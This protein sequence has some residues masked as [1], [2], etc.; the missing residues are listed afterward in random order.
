MPYVAKQTILE[1]AGLLQVVR[2]EGLAGT[3]NGT[4]KV[5]TTDYKPI[6]DADYDDSVDSSDVAVYVGGVKVVVVGVVAETG[7]ITLRD[8]PS[9]AAVVTA[10]YRY[11][12][13]SD[14]AVEEARNEAQEMVNETLDS[15]DTVPYD[16]EAV[17]ATIRKIVKWYAAGL[18]LMQDYGPNQDTEQTSKNGDYKMKRAEGWLDKYSSTIGTDSSAGNA[19]AEARHEADIFETDYAKYSI[20]DRFMRDLG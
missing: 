10:D 11:S 2:G 17:P 5:F 6:S 8:A 14:D 19:S 4:N 1:E 13:V 18:L 9:A 7:R 3:A 12:N 15:V 20:D 16:D